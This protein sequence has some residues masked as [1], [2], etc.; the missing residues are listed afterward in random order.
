MD[1][2]VDAKGFLVYY[3]M[4][5]R[6]NKFLTNPKIFMVY[7]S[8]GIKTEFAIDNNRPS[9]MNSSQQGSISWSGSY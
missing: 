3:S 6:Q 8:K 7:G 4:I 1:W 5:N 9:A 2:N